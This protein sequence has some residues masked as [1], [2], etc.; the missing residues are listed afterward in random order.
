G[1][2]AVAAHTG[3]V[4]T[5]AGKRLVLEATQL[6]QL[7]ALARRVDDAAA[8]GPPSFQIVAEELAGSGKSALREQQRAEDMYPT[9]HRDD[10]SSA[11][12]RAQVLSAARREAS[13]SR[14]PPALAARGRW[15]RRSPAR[16]PS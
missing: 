16:P 8:D 9:S 12:P 6:L 13:G 14:G 5:A 3:S 7:L 10:L 15:C 1:H 11:D 2:T 4:A